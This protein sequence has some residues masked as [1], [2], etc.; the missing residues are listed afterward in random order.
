MIYIILACVY[1]GFLIYNVKIVSDEITRW[2]LLQNDTASLNVTNL[3]A[4]ESCYKK[5]EKKYKKDVN[6]FFY[7]E[8]YFNELYYNYQNDHELFIP[9]L[10]E[11]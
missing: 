4:N 8:F 7:N 6:D 1:T 9:F 2:I 3:I 10:I 5:E 11:C